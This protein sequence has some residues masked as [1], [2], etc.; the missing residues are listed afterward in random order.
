MYIHT[1]IHK[2]YIHG[3]IVLRLQVQQATAMPPSEAKQT[4]TFNYKKI[5]RRKKGISHA[6]SD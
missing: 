1:Y 2:S 5:E 6:F 3:Q 4:P